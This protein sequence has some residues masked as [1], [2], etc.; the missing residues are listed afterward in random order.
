MFTKEEVKEFI[1]K[2]GKKWLFPDFYN[3]VTWYVVTLGAGIILTPIPFKLVIYNWIIESINLN[4]GNII[5]LSEMGSNTADYWLGYSLITLALLHN[6]FSKWLLHQNDVQER[7]SAEKIN[8]VDEALFKEFL[9][10]FPSGSRSAYLLETHDFGNSFNLESL[11]NID[12]FVDEWNCPEKSFID[13]DLE[14]IRKE[15]W[16]KCYKF[17]WLVA[18]KSSPTHGGL[19]S[20]VPDRVR[21]D[22]DWP[23]WVDDDVKAVNKMASEVFVLHQSFI[24]FMRETLKC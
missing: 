1:I 6:V 13:Q 16:A 11:N 21:G 5:T 12:K 9:E 14:A 4:S 3:K 22:W 2:F 20:V 10:V 15:L 24:K 18:E 17:S 19:Q 7:V 23:K 8:A